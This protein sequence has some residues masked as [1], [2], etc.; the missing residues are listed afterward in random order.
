MR[1]E[2]TRLALACVLL[3][4]AP[5]ALP[6]KARRR[7]RPSSA[8]RKSR[9][10]LRRARSAAAAGAAGAAQTTAAQTTAPPTEGSTPPGAIPE[11]EGHHRRQ[12]ELFML[13]EDA[14]GLRESYASRQVSAAD[15]IRSRERNFLSATG[16]LDERPEETL[17]CDERPRCRADVDLLRAKRTPS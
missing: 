7:P 9:L 4:A 15:E 2:R 14:Q 11:D 12:P 16:W 6:L 5:S 1:T 17:R 3:L 10:R 13:M 8:P